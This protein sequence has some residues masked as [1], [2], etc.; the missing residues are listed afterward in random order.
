MDGKKIDCPIL[1]FLSHGFPLLL[2]CR[3]NV[4]CTFPE[5][6]SSMNHSGLAVFHVTD[7]NGMKLTDESVI[8]Y[9]EQVTLVKSS[10][11]PERHI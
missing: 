10:I 6:F 9:I 2:I 4:H 7:Q 8:S 11:D 1:C 3:Q 5:L